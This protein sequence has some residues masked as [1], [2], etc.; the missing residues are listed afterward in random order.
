[1]PSG[2]REAL[3]EL[4]ELLFELRRVIHDVIANLP[5]YDRRVPFGI[6]IAGNVWP[7][8]LYDQL[9]ERRWF[10]RMTFTLPMVTGWLEQNPDRSLVLKFHGNIGSVLRDLEMWDK[11]MHRSVL[12]R[13]HKLEFERAENIQELTGWMLAIVELWQT[14]LLSSA[15]APGNTLIN[16]STDCLTSNS[17]APSKGKKKPGGKASGNDDPAG[18][19]LCKS[20]LLAHHRFDP[21]TCRN[22]VPSNLEPITTDEMIRSTSLSAATISRFFSKSP[23]KSRRAYKRFCTDAYRLAEKLSALEYAIREHHHH[24]LDQNLIAAGDGE[25]DE[26]DA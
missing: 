9:K 8:H 15:S 4:R 22:G 20:A 17:A 19:L 21:A 16:T 11:R 14:S 12:A 7:N 23:F 26:F 18:F 13:R 6:E 25:P 2:I 3:A 5:P 1:M 10:Q 24:S